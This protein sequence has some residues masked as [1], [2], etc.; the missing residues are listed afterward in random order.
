ML[1]EGKKPVEAQ[2]NG[3]SLTVAFRKA[4]PPMI[5]RFD[6]ERNHSFT[7][8]IQGEEGDW[9]L[10]VTSPKGDFFAVTRF[11]DKE[12][13]DEAF[14][15]VQKALTRHKSSWRKWLGRSVIALVLLIILGIVGFFAMTFYSFNSMTSAATNLGTM[16]NLGQQAYPAMQETYDG[17]PMPA[18]QA[19]QMPEDAAP[20]QPPPSEPKKVIVDDG[21]PVPADQMLEMP[22]D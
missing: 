20:Q 7:L 14:N 18:D 8:A 3:Q 16:H 17:S 22:K 15:N 5:W 2:V 9:E 13:A 10:G 6:L 1:L 4:N 11:L 12:A 19:L 21:A